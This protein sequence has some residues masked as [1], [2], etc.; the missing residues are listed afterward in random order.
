MNITLLPWFYVYRLIL[1]LPR[2][3]IAFERRWWYVTMLL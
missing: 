1:I 2:G 3:A